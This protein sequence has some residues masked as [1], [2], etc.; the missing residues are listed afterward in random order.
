VPYQRTIVFHGTADQTV[1]PSNALSIL[2]GATSQNNGAL[3]SRER[4]C[5]A[6]GRSYTRSV[7]T[8]PNGATIV[9]CWLIDGGGHAWSGGRAG[10][11]YTESHG[12]DATAEMMRFFT[13]R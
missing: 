8:A 13:V 4:G 7:L 3:L 10:G 9:E 1:H 2:E 12:P 6:E 11:S 5:S